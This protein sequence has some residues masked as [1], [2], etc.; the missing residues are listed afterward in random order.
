MRGNKLHLCCKDFLSIY[1][2]QGSITCLRYSVLCLP[3]IYISKRDPGNKHP[4]TY[5][6][7]FLPKKQKK[8]CQC[9]WHTRHQFDPCIRKIP[10]EEGRATQSSILAWRIPWIE[11]PGGLQSIGSHRVGHNWSDLACTHADLYFRVKG[12][13]RDCFVQGYKQE[14]PLPLE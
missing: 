8:T 3:G 13:V 4:V 12:D 1:N 9:W 14:S 7:M 6:I 11:E 10:W 2:V 5:W